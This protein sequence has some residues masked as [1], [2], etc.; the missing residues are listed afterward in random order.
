MTAIVD[1][2]RVPPHT[3]VNFVVENAVPGCAV[4]P[5]T[6]TRQERKVIVVDV[7]AV[8]PRHHQ[9]SLT[10]TCRTFCDRKVIGIA[11]IKRCSKAQPL[12]LLVLVI[13]HPVRKVFFFIRRQ[14]MLLPV[15]AGIH[16]FED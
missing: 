5:N 3:P 4:H 8:A 14:E 1:T 9:A 13:A 10:T 16:I 7:P 6:K 12:I 11:Q 15:I 2:V